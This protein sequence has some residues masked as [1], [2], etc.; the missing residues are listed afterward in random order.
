[1]P[2][3]HF[4]KVFVLDTNIIL[5]SVE[6]LQILSEN[7]K[8]LIVLPE[9]VLDEIDTKKSGFEEINFQAR[10]FGRFLEHAGDVEVSTVPSMGLTLTR[11]FVNGDKNVTI[12]IVSKE[13]Y[14]V[15][16]VDPSIRNDRKIIEIALDMK[17]MYGDDV[18]FVSLDVMCRHR[19]LSK[20]LT[21]ESL[22]KGN[23]V[24]ITSEFLKEVSFNEFVDVM[25][26]YD[27]NP[28][29]SYHNF[30]YD[31]E[32]D[33]R[34]FLT[35]VKNDR[36]EQINEDE[37]RKQIV[38]PM[39]KEQLLFSH[40]LLDP[41]YNVVVAEAIAGS[42][43]NLLST[44]AAMKLIDQKHFKK[45]VYI[46]N[47]I[48]S[49]QKGEDIGYLS[50]NEAK[51]EIYNFPLAD[52]LYY[53]AN[54]MLKRSDSNKSPANREVISEQLIEEKVISLI[55]DYNIQTM[56][57]GAM[58]GRTISNAIVIIDE[59]QN[60]SNSTAQLVL[61]RIDDTCKIIAIGSNNQIDN[62]YI[63]RHTNGL[64]TLMN[65]SKEK[66]NINM[67]CIQLTKVLRGP[68]TEFAEK[69]YTKHKKV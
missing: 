42:G 50:T 43:K 60:M 16:D 62:A 56:W 48:E 17:S 28:D 30:A 25:S 63:N 68:I 67:F 39:N 59:M 1:M 19:A 35:V 51:F 22:R 9:T 11:C 2:R 26:V 23:D 66:H 34:H 27:V 36:L 13:T 3:T 18:V 4:D 7:S 5:D 24:D 46:R 41:F 44:S 33:G 31:I 55:K 54:K 64:T 20:G 45:I 37:L 65:A 32:Q 38:P 29:H 49:L 58:R 57:P 53:I 8:N 47:S 40:A 21:V 69:V 52:T 15:I 12:Q 61:S 10:S 14:S 6:N